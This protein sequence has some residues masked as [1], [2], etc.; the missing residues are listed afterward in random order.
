MSFHRLVA[1]AALA[2]TALGAP[3]PAKT[4]N[5][6]SATTTTLLATSTNK[7]FG[8]NDAAKQAGKLWFGTAADI[9][10]TGEAQD[11]YYMR[12]FQNPHDF[13]EA[14]P[15]NIMKV[16]QTVESFCLLPLTAMFIVRIHRA[17]AE[18]LQLH[19]RRLLHQ[20]RETKWQGSPLPQPH[21]AI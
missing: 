1:I 15:A 7:A 13:G 21:L 20:R 16:G 9:P 5:G 19:R 12:A 14:T 18:R 2:A 17:R 10:G 6:V 3:N 8:L 11:K 4:T